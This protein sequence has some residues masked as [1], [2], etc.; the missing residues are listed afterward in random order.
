[1]GSRQY[2]R[3]D[4]FYLMTHSTHFMYSYIASDR[5]NKVPIKYKTVIRICSA[6]CFPLFPI[7]VCVL[8]HLTPINHSGS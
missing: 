5:G 7:F 8:K 1:M 2:E 4:M 6:S 3:T